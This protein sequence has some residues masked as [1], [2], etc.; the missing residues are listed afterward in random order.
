[1]DNLKG[2]LFDMLLLHDKYQHGEQIS[3]YIN[4][5]DDLEI[6]SLTK[7]ITY[8]IKN[9]NE[10]PSIATIRREAKIITRLNRK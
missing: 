7:A 9:N 5:L 3:T 4:Y 2:S 10:L 6:E 8:L 1:M